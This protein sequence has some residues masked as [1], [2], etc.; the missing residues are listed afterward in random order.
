MRK[1]LLAVAG[2]LSLASPM[3]GGQQAQAGTTELPPLGAKCYPTN[4]VKIKPKA[5]VQLNDLIEGPDSA[6]VA[7]LRFVCSVTSLDGSNPPFTEFLACY[8]INGQN[9]NGPVGPVLLDDQF[10]SDQPI[11]I[12]DENILCVEAELDF[13]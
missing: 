8:S 1:L 7:K 13:D 12:N 4:E 11:T 5:T 6:Q 2:A 10:L 3:V 9:D